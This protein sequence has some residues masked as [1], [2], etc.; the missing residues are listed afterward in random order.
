M[1]SYL[2]EPSANRQLIECASWRMATE[3]VRRDTKLCIRELHPGGGQ[4]DCLAIVHGKQQWL[5]LNRSGSVHVFGGERVHSRV[6]RDIVEDD[7]ALAHWIDRLATELGLPG[8]SAV[9]THRALTYRVI[10]AV[11]SHGAFARQFLEVRS[12]FCDTSG[13]GGGI[14]TNLFAGLKQTQP[15]FSSRSTETWQDA[16]QY[17]FLLAGGKPVAA[18]HESGVAWCAGGTQVNLMSIYRRTRSIGEIVG[19]GFTQILD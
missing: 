19:V 18:W 12:G 9:T 11:L 17:W 1:E 2:G 16:S 13:D 7:A 3:L 8:R 4:Y 14:R 15:H 5:Q 6:W 10:A